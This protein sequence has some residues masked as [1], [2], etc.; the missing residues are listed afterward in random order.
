[1]TIAGI[2]HMKCMS[3]L[4]VWRMGAR[5]VFGRVSW[6]HNW[7]EREY[8]PGEIIGS[9]LMKKKIVNLLMGLQKPGSF[10]VAPTGRRVAKS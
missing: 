7:A 4:Y 3:R 1:M 6:S 10:L 5:R 2:R 9:R 8:D